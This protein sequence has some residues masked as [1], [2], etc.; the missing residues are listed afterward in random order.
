MD[1]DK[2]EDAGCGLE[3]SGSPLRTLVNIRAHWVAFCMML[4]NR[5]DLQ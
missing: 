5:C 4:A 1:I 2:L 3:K